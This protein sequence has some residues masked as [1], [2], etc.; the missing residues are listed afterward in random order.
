ME[1]TRLNLRIFTIILGPIILATYAY[2][3][4]KMSNPEK[5][6]GGI[7]E[8]WR[9]F[10]VICM[11]ISAVGFLIMWWMFLFQ[12]ETQSVEALSWPW[13]SE[14]TGGYNRLF[15]CFCLVMIPSAMWIEMTKFHISQPKKWTPFATIGI[16]IL[17][18]IGNILFMLI[19]WEAW[20]TKIGDLAWLPF[21]GSLMF[22]IQV[23][24]NDAIWWSIAFPWSSGE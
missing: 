6:W 13:Q 23:I 16:L 21:I 9:K 14:S 24:F 11:F 18:S 5:L 3:V 20:Q 2:G 15:I 22:S 10:N 4:S 17:V 7:P 1:L 12:W 8:S 19:S